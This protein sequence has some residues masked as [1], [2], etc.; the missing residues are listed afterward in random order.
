MVEKAPGF[1]G[2]LSKYPDGICGTSKQIEGFALLSM[3]DADGILMNDETIMKECKNEVSDIMKDV[4][5]V[6]EMN[7][8]ESEYGSSG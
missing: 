7:K 1:L 3:T 5:I 2:N 6:E 8:M 4:D